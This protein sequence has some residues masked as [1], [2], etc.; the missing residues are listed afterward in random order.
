[1]RQKH[2]ITLKSQLK[3]LIKVCTTIVLTTENEYGLVSMQCESS[4]KMAIKKFI[5]LLP[6]LKIKR[7][8]L[9][10]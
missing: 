8:L 9:T 6:V 2:I 1:M 5:I 10:N 3:R 4:K 7:L